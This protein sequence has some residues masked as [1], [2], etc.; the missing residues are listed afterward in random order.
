M[1]TEAQRP[2]V[3][4]EPIYLEKEHAATVL[5]LSISTFEELGRTDPTFPRARLLSKRRT[6]Y[7]VSELRTWSASRPVSDLLP[8]PNTGAKKPRK[9]LK[10]AAA[11]A[12]EVVAALHGGHHAA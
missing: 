7:L 3:A 12:A 10:R 9:P 4:I 8:P 6:G 2:L 5:A 1:S 11:A